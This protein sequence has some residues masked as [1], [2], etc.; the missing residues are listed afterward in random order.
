MSGGAGSRLWPLSRQAIPKQLL[1]L[2]TNET[3]VQETAA[4]FTGA[5]FTDPVFICN[6]LHAAPI[7]DQMREMGQSIGTMIVEPMGRNTAP[8]AVVAARHAQICHTGALV[9]LVPADHHVRKPEAFRA[10][11][12]AAIPAAQAG[13]LVTFGITPDRPETGY[14][15]IQQGSDIAPGVFSIKAFKEK[16]DAQTA[17]GYL[18]NGDYVWNAGI[19]LFSPE[20]FLDEVNTFASEIDHAASQAYA[21]AKNKDGVIWL[22]CST[23]EACPG[24]SI[25]YAVMESTEKAAVVPCDMGWSDIG[26]FASLQEVRADDLGNAVTGDVLTVDVSGSLILT[27]GPLVAAV[28]LENVAVIVHQG[29]VLVVNL[30]AAQDVKKIVERLKSTGRTDCL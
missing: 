18:K 21:A 30:D 1:P 13:R 10:A 22:D 17:S 8:C 2:V 29:Q 12:E 15:Y 11:I 6:A 20:V 9:L 16:P 5:R 25:D 4:R 26:S 23:F 28:G 3:M 14:G 19:F 24:Q 27:D 7:T